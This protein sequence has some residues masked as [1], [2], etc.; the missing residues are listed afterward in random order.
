MKNSII[1]V[2]LFA[3]FLSSCQE[4]ERLV[5]SD[6]G[7]LYFTYPVGDDSVMYSFTM[8]TY[9]VDT[10]KLNVKLLG[11][12]ESYD[13]KFKLRLNEGTTAIEGTHF[14]KLENEYILKSGSTSTVVPVYINKT[15]DLQQ[16]IESIDVSIVENETFT[17]GFKDKNRMRYFITDQI[18]RPSYWDD[19]LINYFTEYSRVK[20]QICIILMGHDFPL[21]K[22]EIDRDPERSYQYYMK[23]GRKAAMYFA[24]NKVYDENGRLIETWDPF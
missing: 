4:N 12:P 13:R 7:A 10:L 16:N 14:K 22:D 17:I 9:D 8:V 24:M 6:K 19:L 15:E 1:I 23:M 3:L 2:A 18:V 21:T 20:H 5:Y 11:R